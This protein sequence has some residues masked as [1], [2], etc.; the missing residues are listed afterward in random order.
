MFS[1]QARPFRTHWVDKREEPIVSEWDWDAINMLCRSKRSR[2]LTESGVQT[3]NRTTLKHFQI[4]RAR[5]LL[6]SPL[7]PEEFLRRPFLLRSRWLIEGYNVKSQRACKF[8]LGAPSE[9]RVALYEPKSKRPRWPFPRAFGAS[10]QDRQLLIDSLLLCSGKDLADLKL[11]VFCDG[12]RLV[13]SDGM[14]T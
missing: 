8:Y 6:A 7:T 2:Q 5:D 4:G 9:L 3:V 14:E 13:P 11:R 12:L 10:R 1:L